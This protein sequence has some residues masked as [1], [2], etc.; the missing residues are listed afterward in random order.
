MD[1]VRG[2]HR[3]DTCSPNLH[4]IVISKAIF[5]YTVAKENNQHF[6]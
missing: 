2:Y 4:T 5:Q 3:S 1:E 6:K